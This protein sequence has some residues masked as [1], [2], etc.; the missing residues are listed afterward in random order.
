RVKTDLGFPAGKMKT[1]LIDLE[2][3]FPADVT[4]RK[5]RLSTELEIY[6]DRLAWAVGVEDAQIIE[7]PVSLASAELRY[8]G[9]SV[10]EKAGHSSPEKPLYD[11]ILTTGQRWRDLEGYYTR[12]G[13]VTELLAGVEGRMVLMNAGD[14]LVLKFPE[15]PPVRPGYRRDFV[16]VGNGWIKDGDLNSVFSKTVLPLPTHASNDYSMPPAGLENDPVYRRFRSDWAEFHTRYVAAEGYRN[17]L[18]RPAGE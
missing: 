1:V 17:A 10:I 5:L 14:E 2:D 12:F 9:F 15:L 6:W 16:F 3:V 13:D 11:Q 7:Q 4:T 8:R 18:R